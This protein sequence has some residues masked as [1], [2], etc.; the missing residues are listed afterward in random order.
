MLIRTRISLIF[1]AAARLFGGPPRVPEPAP[2]DGTGSG[3]K[4]LRAAKKEKP[5]SLAARLLCCCALCF[6]AG[7]RR[8]LRHPDAVHAGAAADVHPDP[9]LG[10]P[11]AVRRSS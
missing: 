10:R 1:L 11:D 9:R 7:F 5:G 8:R 2:E 6:T 3:V 4:L